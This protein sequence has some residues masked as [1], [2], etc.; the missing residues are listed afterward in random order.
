MAKRCP[1]CGGKLQE[2][3]YCEYCDLRIAIYEKIHHVSL[4][5]F[6]KGLQ[7]AT[8]RDLSG[9]ISYL[10]R[11]IAFDK[12]N[13]DARN[14]LGLVHYEMGESALAIEQWTLSHRVD[15]NPMAIDYLKR[16][17]FKPGAAEKMNSVIKKYNQSLAYVKQESFD[18]A[19]IQLRKVVSLSPNYIQALN[20]LALCYIMVN[21]RAKARKPLMQALAIDRTNYPAGAYLAIL[22]GG[23]VSKADTEEVEEE[24]HPKHAQFSYSHFN[25]SGAFLQFVTIVAGV[26]IGLALAWFLI[27]PGRISDRDDEIM[28]LTSELNGFK[29][30]ESDYMTSIATLEEQLAAAE[31]AGSDSLQDAEKYK[32]SADEV[33]KI[34]KALQA[35]QSGNSADAADLLLTVDESVLSAEAKAVLTSLKESVFPGVANSLYIDGYNRYAANDFDESIRLLNKSLQLDEKSEPLYFLARSYQKAGDESTAIRL[36]NEFLSKYPNVTRA[37][38]ARYYLNTLQ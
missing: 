10:R 1:Q 21:E 31:S 37:A 18:L 15:Q 35:S 2:H 26:L 36:F 17:R 3:N 30:R 34:L 9:A 16:L 23:V 19:I 5:F 8:I 25:M 27:M 22:N 7:R 28:A 4:A 33:V 38:D 14:L 20:L 32:V 29:S 24:L 6:E 13:V 11:S 12:N